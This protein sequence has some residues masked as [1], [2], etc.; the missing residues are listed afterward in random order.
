MMK[1][2]DDALEAYLRAVKIDKIQALEA[3]RHIGT[4]YYIKKDEKKKKVL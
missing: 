2:Q 4:I 3:F 1:K